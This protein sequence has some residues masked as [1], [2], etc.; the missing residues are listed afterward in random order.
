[1]T[2]DLRETLTPLIEQWQ[3]RSSQLLRSPAKSI[4]PYP[5]TYNE[6]RSEQLSACAAELADAVA[7]VP[8]SPQADAAV[9]SLKDYAEDLRNVTWLSPVSAAEMNRRDRWLADELDK[10]AETLTTASILP[11][12]R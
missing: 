6:G 7:L 9:L 5:K 11:P 8:S 2:I 10:I 3:K 12:S 4:S 1:M